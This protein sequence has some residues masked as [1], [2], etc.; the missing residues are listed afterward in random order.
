[1]IAQIGLEIAAKGTAL[2]ALHI[3]LADAV[4][5]PCFQV[6]AFAVGVEIV[7]QTVVQL[8]FVHAQK[9][10]TRAKAQHFRFAAGFHPCDLHCHRIHLLSDRTRRGRHAPSPSVHNTIM[11]PITRKLGLL[12]DFLALVVTAVA[13]CLVGELQRAAVAALDQCGASSFQTL[14]RRLSRRALE[15]CLLGTAIFLHLL[16]GFISSAVI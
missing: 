11:P 9:L 13:T 4:C 7:V 8:V 15:R 6:E 14:L 5:H 10:V 1:M 3:P 12:D 2:R 16:D